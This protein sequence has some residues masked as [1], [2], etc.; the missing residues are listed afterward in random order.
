MIRSLVAVL[1][2]AL[3]LPAAAA[4]VWSTTGSTAR[5]VVCDSGTEAAPTLITE[6]ITLN[7]VASIG[8]VAEAAVGQTFT[9]APAGTLRIYIWD[10]FVGA[11]ARCMDCGE[12]VI[13]AAS[14]RRQ[15]FASF[16]IGERRGRF[17]LV[18]NGVTLSAGTLTIYL[19]A[20][21]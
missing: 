21:R 17:A 5:K 19:T 8:V 14:E 3:S 6:G 20:G 15:A 13:T 18:P 10:E 2:L 7:T 9:A 16:T 11:W 12:P 4:C 1:C